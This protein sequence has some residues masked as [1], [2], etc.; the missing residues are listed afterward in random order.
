MCR[1]DLKK[2]EKF[3][4]GKACENNN[5]CF[6]DVCLTYGITLT[7]VSIVSIKRPHE[8]KSRRKTAI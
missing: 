6:H 3:I 4:L 2:L 8:Q 5:Y 1:W 7:I